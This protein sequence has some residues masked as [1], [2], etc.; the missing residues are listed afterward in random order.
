MSNILK[1]IVLF[2][3]FV[4]LGYSQDKKI[5]YC[6]NDTESGYLQIFIMNEDGSDKKQL[7]DISENCMHP[8]WSPDG[9]QL[10]F[11]TD[12]G[13]IYLMRD[14]NSTKPTNLFY[15]YNGTYPVF[16]PAGDQ[17][18]YNDE[19][20]D[21]LSIMVIDTNQYGAEPQLLSDGG[22]SNMY[23]IS[24]D[25]NK[26]YFSTFDGGTKVIKVMDL[27]DTTDNYIEK[28]S[29]N[30]EANLEPDVSQDGQKVA[31]ASFDANLK[32]T[33]RILEN[34]KESALTKGMPSSNVP[35]FSPDGS[36]IAF[37]VIDGN[38]VSLYVM[39]ADGSGKKNL[40]AKGGNIGTF[41]WINNYEILYDAGS[42]SQ[43]I[44]AMANDTSGENYILAEGGFNLHPVIQ[45]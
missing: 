38:D 4:N 40:H 13:Y 42:E 34:G 3:V 16:M 30:D 26:I 45:K 12:R 19:Y 39:N 35:R 8:Q 1:V 25:G 18:V 15:L 22:Y 11:Y 2:L 17:V 21:V 10:S 24:A 28:I 20:E 29:K 33:I 14:I 9:K 5:A 44:I 36:K 7:T 27:N 37:V 23:V 32:G 31:Y 43:T 6:S 41:Q